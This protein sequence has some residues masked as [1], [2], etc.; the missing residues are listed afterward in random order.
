VVFDRMVMEFSLLCAARVGNDPFSLDWVTCKAFGEHA[1]KS[2]DFG[3]CTGGWVMIQ[4]YRIVRGFSKA[5]MA[6]TVPSH[7]VAP[8]IL[9][10]P[11]D[12]R[13]E[14]SPAS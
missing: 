2:F 9:R 11:Q 7:A 6:L 1:I 5:L 8:L 12:E 14:A 10:V 3:L 4:D 13:E